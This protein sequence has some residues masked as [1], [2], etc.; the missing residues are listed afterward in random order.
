MKVFGITGYSGMGKTTLLERLL[1]ELAA[2]SLRVSLIKHSHK[3]IEVDKPG[4][5]SWRLRQAGCQELLLMGHRRWA[6]MREL[7]SDDEPQLEELLA[8][9]QDCDL[10]LIEGFKQGD[11]PKLEVWRASEEKPPLWPGPGI[12]GMACPREDLPM[13]RARER[14][15]PLLALEDVGAVADLV[16]AHARTAGRDTPVMAFGSAVAAGSAPGQALASVPRAPGQ[17]LN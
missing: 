14:R 6:L 7:Q 12:V 8:R 4:K 2:R 16:V 10:V 3:E 11:F 5:D 13:L 9:L 15:C 1:P 17:R